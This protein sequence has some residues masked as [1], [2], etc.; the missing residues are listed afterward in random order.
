MT[1]VHTDPTSPIWHPTDFM[2]ATCLACD[3]QLPLEGERLQVWF[4]LQLVVARNHVRRQPLERFL[5]LVC[6]FAT[7]S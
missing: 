6:H 4:Q 5:L 1:N 2:V 7:A 3:L